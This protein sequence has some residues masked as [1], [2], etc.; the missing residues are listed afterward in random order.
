MN[1]SNGDLDS[2][3]LAKYPKIM[4]KPINI[5]IFLILFINFTYEF[6]EPHAGFLLALSMSPQPFLIKNP[7]KKAKRKLT[8]SKGVHMAAPTHIT[9][10]RKIYPPP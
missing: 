3:N 2:I 6:T 1:R 10:P 8:G 9:P 4:T 7:P 5:N